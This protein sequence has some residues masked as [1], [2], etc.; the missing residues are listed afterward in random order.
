MANSKFN[1]YLTILPGKSI[2]NDPFTSQCLDNKSLCIGR[3]SINAADA[4]GVLLFQIKYFWYDDLL[5]YRTKY[6]NVGNILC[7]Q[8]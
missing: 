2:K 6:D 7:N 1:W 8:F 5:I 3:F 4:L